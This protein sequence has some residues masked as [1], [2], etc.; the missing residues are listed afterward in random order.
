M[1][2]NRSGVHLGDL[3][4]ANTNASRA[5]HSNQL[6]QLP[7]LSPPL[8]FFMV[9]VLVASSAPRAGF[10]LCSARCRWLGA[11]WP[12]GVSLWQSKDWPEKPTPPQTCL[13]HFFC[14]GA[15]AEEFGLV[16]HRA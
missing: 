6:Y 15:K 7:L 3:L 1:A 16:E 13:C 9:S 4:G 5:P 11:D 2:G 10:S 8:V 12:P 14:S